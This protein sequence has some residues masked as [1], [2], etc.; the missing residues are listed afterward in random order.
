MGQQLKKERIKEDRVKVT[1][2]M[3]V[4]RIINK[5]AQDDEEDDKGR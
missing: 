2:G 5:G 1:W 4:Q 3:M